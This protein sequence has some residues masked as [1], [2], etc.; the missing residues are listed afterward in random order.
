M[1]F[2]N[3][4]FEKSEVENAKKIVYCDLVFG[5]KISLIGDLKVDNMASDEIVFKNKKNR[6]KITGRNLSIYSMSKGEFRIEGDVCGVVREWV[7]WL[8]LR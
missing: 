6:F 4:F 7:M 3:D 8:E 1:S 2:F 5:E